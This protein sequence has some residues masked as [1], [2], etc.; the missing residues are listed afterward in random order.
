MRARLLTALLAVALSG[1]G[2]ASS[3]LLTRAEA[4]EL[5]ERRWDASAEEV[6][7]ATWLTLREDGWSVREVDRVAGTLAA[8]KGG[9]AWELEVSARGAEQRV[10]AAPRDEQV[11]REVLVSLDDALEAGTRRLLAAWR[12]LPEWRFD[13][14]RN[15]LAVPGFSASPP[16][17]WE[18]LDFD[19]SRRHVTLQQRRARGGANPTL[20]VEVD[21]R[22]PEPVLGALLERAAG[23]ALSARQRLTLP[24]EVPSREDAAGLHGE[25]RVLDGTAPRDVSWHA[26]SAVL[27]ATEVHWVM[28]CPRDEAEACA[29]AWAEVARSVVR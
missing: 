13:G 20:L 11:S 25:L 1:P 26:L 14:R 6:F 29:D 3:R 5:A 10:A 16:R 2:C 7:D 23:L 18:S 28:V 27:G 15:V 21:R 19:V 9:R 24:D 12:E 4:R 17:A 22:R 8:T